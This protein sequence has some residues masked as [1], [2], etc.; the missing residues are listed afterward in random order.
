[1]RPWKR[2]KRYRQ[3]RQNRQYHRHDK[4]NEITPYLP[5][6][7]ATNTPSLQSHNNNVSIANQAM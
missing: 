6:T 4:T 7:Y 2:R 5:T 3:G 1:M